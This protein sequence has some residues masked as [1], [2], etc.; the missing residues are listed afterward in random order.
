[1]S[2]YSVINSLLK[3]YILMINVKR[4]LKVKCYLWQYTVF[5]LYKLYWN[6]LVICFSGVCAL[7][8]APV[9]DVEED[10]PESATAD[11]PAW[12]HYTQPTEPVHKCPLQSDQQRNHGV[13]STLHYWMYLTYKRREEQSSRH[14]LILAAAEFMPGL[15]CLETVTPASEPF[16]YQTWKWVWGQ[17]AS[18]EQMSDFWHPSLS[19]SDVILWNHLQIRRVILATVDMFINSVHSDNHYHHFPGEDNG[20]ALV[21]IYSFFLHLDSAHDHQLMTVSSNSYILNCARLVKMNNN[22]SQYVICQTDSF[23]NSQSPSR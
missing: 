7:P 10:R 22:W 2:H 18:K 13:D 12:P 6:I 1:M 21:T 5:D 14:V 9:Q 3:V 23:F 17:T 20:A 11:S 19:Y 16:F 4:G 15:E 8:H